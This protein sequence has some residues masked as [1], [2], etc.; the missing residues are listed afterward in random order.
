MPWW[1]WVLIIVAVIVFVP[2]KAKITKR[3]LEKWKK[4]REEPD[5]DE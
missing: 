2:I 4:E 3:F 1:G 5:L